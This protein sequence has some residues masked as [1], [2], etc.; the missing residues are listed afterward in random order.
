MEKNSRPIIAMKTLRLLLL[1]CALALLGAPAFA[2]TTVSITAPDNSA[3]EK[4]AGQAANPGIIRIARTGSTAGALTVF[5]KS[6]SGTA[7]RGRTTNLG[8][9]LRLGWRSRRGA[10]ASILR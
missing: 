5:L 3:G 1:T 4:L 2:Q 7:V 10:A 8:L 9:R 6:I